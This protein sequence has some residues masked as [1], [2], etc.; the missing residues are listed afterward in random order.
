MSSEGT[1]AELWWAVV[2]EANAQS[3]SV[4]ETFFDVAEASGSEIDTVG[5]KGAETVIV[6]G[7]FESRPERES[8][9]TLLAE[10]LSNFGFEKEAAT[11][12]EI[13]EVENEDWL[14]EWKR[15]WK[16][17]SCGSFVISPPWDVPA[18]PEGILIK[19]EPSMAFGTGTHETTRLCLEFI[20]E[21]YQNGE[22]FLDVGTG[23]GILSIAVA[24]LNDGGSKTEI[25]GL[26]TDIDS[27]AIA[28]GNLVLNNT[29]HV[30]MEAGTLTADVENFD[31]VCA[32]VTID[33]I[34]PM[35][36]LLVEK[37]KRILVLSGI[38]R[39]QESA[40]I[41]ALS[42]FGFEDPA[43]KRDGEWIAVAVEL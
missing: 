32:N 25:F 43:V 24:K 35:L 20:S 7:Y 28:R 31:F 40:I 3:E 2:V 10:T 11:I 26:D 22:S 1:K 19:I 34:V 30:R 15:H 36:E 37:A 41:E 39:E 21:L 27:I 14:A 16:P 9:E 13:K 33:V 6:K 12:G 29:P 8:L 4:V 23:T 38:L 5:K 42:G 17:T 18:E